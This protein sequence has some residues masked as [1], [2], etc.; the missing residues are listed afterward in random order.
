MNFH[1]ILLLSYFF[2]PK[3]IF[4]GA[5]DDCHALFHT[6]PQSLPQLKEKQRTKAILQ[7]YEKPKNYTMKLPLSVQVSSSTQGYYPSF[8]PAWFSFSNPYHKQKCSPVKGD[9]KIH[10]ETQSELQN[11]F[12]KVSNLNLSTGKR[13][14]NLIDQLSFWLSIIKTIV[15]MAI[16]R[17]VEN[18]AQTNATAFCSCNSSMWLYQ[19]QDGRKQYSVWLERLCYLRSRMIYVSKQHFLCVST[20]LSYSTS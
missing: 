5:S 18:T 10:S 16:Q 20:N 14:L 19:Q 2:A 1:K 6:I 13:E 12:T 15:A 3:A 7:G 8:F 9:T 17:G 4:N 11:C